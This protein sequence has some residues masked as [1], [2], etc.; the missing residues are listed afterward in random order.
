MT[1]NEFCLKYPEVVPI[2]NDSELMVKYMID[3]NINPTI[4]YS[5]VARYVKF[6]NEYHDQCE[7]F[8]K[9]KD[10]KD[11]WNNMLEE[12]KNKKIL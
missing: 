4:D 9:F 5:L 6:Y 7:D 3:E 1:H 11:D 12:K 2:S 10:L 8:M